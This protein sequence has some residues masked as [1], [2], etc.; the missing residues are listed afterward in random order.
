MIMQIAYRSMGHQ[1]AC[2]L[3]QERLLSDCGSHFGIYLVQRFTETEDKA[4]T[5]QVRIGCN[6]SSCILRKKWSAFAPRAE[7]FWKER[8]L[9]QKRT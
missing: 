2:D 6:S 5:E 8:T 9:N 7:A 1:A 4:F 3:A